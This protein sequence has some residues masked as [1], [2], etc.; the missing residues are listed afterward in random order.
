MVSH[1]AIRFS[2][3]IPL[4]Q[5]AGTIGRALDALVKQSY[6]ATEVV[7]VDDGSTDGGAAIALEYQRDDRLPMLRLIRQENAGVACARNRGIEAPSGEWIGFLDADDEYATDYLETI[8]SLLEHYPEAGWAAT[9]YRRRGAGI[10]DVV[11]NPKGFKHG[12]HGLIA[13]PY[14]AWIRGYFIFTSSICARRSTL[15]QLGTPGPFEPG[16]SWAEDIDVWWRLG[17]NSPLAFCAVPGSVYHLTVGNNLNSE[18]RAPALELP[19]AFRALGDRLRTGRMPAAQRPT[20][21][22]LLPLMLAGNARLCAVQGH[23]RVALMRLIAEGA[24]TWRLGPRTLARIV[25]RRRR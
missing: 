6:P 7:V 10:D 21:R 5:K 1:S 23:H 24:W 25:A 13:D 18:Q 12:D 11:A 20:A 14:E 2:I 22:R 8:R 16:Q 4:Y 15:L 17:E 9:G 19:H 3:V